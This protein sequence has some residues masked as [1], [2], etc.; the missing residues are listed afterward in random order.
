VS[1]DAITLCVC[2]CCCL[3]RYRLSPENFGYTFVSLRGVL[4]PRGLS[5]VYELNRRRAGLGFRGIAQYLC[6]MPRL[7]LKI[8]H[9]CVVPNSCLLA[10]HDH[11]PT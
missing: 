9:S 11:V 4:S 6:R 5:V 7:L 1:F 2:F 8:G 10:I 3:F